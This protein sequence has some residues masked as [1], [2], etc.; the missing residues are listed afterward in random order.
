MIGG[1]GGGA[2]DGPRVKGEGATAAEGRRCGVLLVV[3]TVMVGIAGDGGGV[4]GARLGV[5]GGLTGG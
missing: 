5:E 1:Q 2:R 4:Q 3:V